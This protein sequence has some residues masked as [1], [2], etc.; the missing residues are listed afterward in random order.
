[1]YNSFRI[2]ELLLIT[3]HTGSY[4]HPDMFAKIAPFPPGK[5]LIG[6]VSVYTLLY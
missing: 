5:M 4:D 6:K 1:V 3:D 2:R